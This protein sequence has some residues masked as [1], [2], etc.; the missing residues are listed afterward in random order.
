MQVS[1]FSVFHQ[2]NIND[3]LN[4]LMGYLFTAELFNLFDDL[5]VRLVLLP[6]LPNTDLKF[7]KAIKKNNS[8]RQICSKP[9]ERIVANFSNSFCSFQFHLQM[10]YHF[11][12]SHPVSYCIYF[13]H[14]K[15]VRI[16]LLKNC[17]LIEELFPMYVSWALNA[18]PFLYVQFIEQQGP[19][20]DLFLQPDKNLQ[21]LQ[22]HK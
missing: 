14:V 3:K 8:A 4:Q 21:V 22:W 20:C 6:L 10:L 9:C 18:E 11:R 17:C 16:I 2:F 13:F 5:C 7:N 12:H 19:I 15:C 1:P